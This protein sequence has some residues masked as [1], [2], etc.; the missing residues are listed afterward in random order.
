VI[1]RSAICGA[2]GWLR[3]IADFT[4]RPWFILAYGGNANLVPSN[5]GRNS[6][7]RPKFVGNAPPTL[8][9][10]ILYWLMDR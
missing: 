8:S 6:Q 1:R 5:S 4:I 2:H 10:G 7:Q 9:L 3:S